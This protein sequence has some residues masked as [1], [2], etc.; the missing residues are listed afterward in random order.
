MLNIL[1]EISARRNLIF[2]LSAKDLKIRYSRPMLG[3]AWVFLSPFLTVAVFYTVFSLILKIR[4][5]EAPFAFYLMSAIFTW[6]FFQDSIMCS[7]TSLVDNK[8]LI[9]ESNFPHYLIPFSIVVTNFINFLPCLAILVITSLVLNG[10]SLLTL[11]LPAIIAAHFIIILGLS[12]ISSIIYVRFRDIKYILE[13]V[14]LLL[15]Y[16]TPAFYSLSFVKESFSPILYKAYLYNPL[17]IVLNLYRVTLLK[18]F[19]NRFQNS[20]GILP[21]IFTLI[22]FTF[23][24]LVS[25]SYFYR[26]N[27][28]TINDYLS[29]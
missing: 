12:I 19:Y 5:Q 9:K 22:I 16:L 4:I 27:K 25:A 21:A 24:I 6:R 26:K 20:L 8:N 1:K 14:L 28:N 11:F 10:I 17:T 23:I 7:T 29:Y 18:G 15:F 3:I 13:V 2:Q